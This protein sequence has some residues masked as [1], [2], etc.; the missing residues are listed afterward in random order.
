MLSLN[1]P[2]LLMALLVTLAGCSDRISIAEQKMAEIRSGAGQPIEPLPE[3]DPVD[4]YAYGAHAVRSPFVAQSL[5][6]MQAGR[7]Q[8][9]NSTTPDLERKRE[10]LESYELAELVDKGRVA[11]IDGQMHA[12]ILAPDGLTHTVSIGSYMGKNHGQITD[13]TSKH[14]KLEEIVPNAQLGFVKK[15]TILEAQSLSSGNTN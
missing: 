2:F 5:L 8:D 3:P 12:L 10:Y 11:L 13:I 9:I 15:E 14:I 4:D 1:K 6:N 7:M